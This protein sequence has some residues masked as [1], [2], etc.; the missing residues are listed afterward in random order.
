MA[1][2]VPKFWVGKK[3]DPPNYYSPIATR[4]SP[5][6]PAIGDK[7]WFYLRHFAVA[8]PFTKRYSPSIAFQL[9]NL[10]TSRF[11]DK[12]GSAGALPSQF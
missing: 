11:A 6:L 8:S 9:A 1:P 7:P 2:G 10:P 12:F 3:P 4:H 5:P